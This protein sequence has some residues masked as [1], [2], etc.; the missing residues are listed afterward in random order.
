MKPI[1]MHY[2][3]C[4]Q[5]YNNAF[6]PHDIE[7]KNKDDLLVIG[8]HD[9]ICG[10]FTNN[11]RSV[12]TFEYADCIEED[13]DN[14]HTEVYELQLHPETIQAALPGVGF[15]WLGSKSNM[16]Q[17]GIFGPRPRG[18]IIFS[19]GKVADKER[20][21]QLL[22]RLFEFMPYFDEKS[23]RHIQILCRM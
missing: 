22:D 19:L 14:N 10:L 17:K 20:Y 13:C 8:T 3:D 15:I 23:S 16:I 5:Q 21:R 6:Y 18:H 7:V 11:H 9:H 2:A 4:V 12:D 1:H